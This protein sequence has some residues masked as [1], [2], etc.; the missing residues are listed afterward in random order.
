MTKVMFLCAMAWP[1]WDTN[2]NAWFDGK[3]G[4]W[5]FV[6]KKPAQ[7]RSVNRP[8]GTLITKPVNVNGDVYKKMLLE[9]VLPAIYE[10]WPRGAG[11][12]EEGR[13]EIIIQEDNAKPHKASIR[14]AIK[15]AA[16]SNGWN[17]SVTTQPPNSPDLNVLDLGF[18]NSIQSLQYKKRSKDIDHLIAN[19]EKAFDETEREALNNVF[20]S[21]QACMEATLGA[22]GDNNYKLPHMGKASLLREGTLPISIICNDESLLAGQQLLA[23]SSSASASS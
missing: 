2:Q 6:E 10:K 11:N 23:T 13:P 15:E 18:F 1:Q 5:P 22:E 3:I 7:R 8:A 19:V 14:D 17:I 9:K 16:A 4:I 12:D 21:L 20:L